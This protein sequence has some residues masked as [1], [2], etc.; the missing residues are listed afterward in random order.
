MPYS[1][2]MPEEDIYVQGETSSSYEPKPR[3]GKGRVCSFP[4]C[5]TPLSEYNEGDRCSLH[6]HHKIGKLRKKRR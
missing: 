1:C 2:A 6:P 3:F 5:K 4:R